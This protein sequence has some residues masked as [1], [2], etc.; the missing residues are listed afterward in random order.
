M[1]T[2]NQQLNEI[3]PLSVTSNIFFADLVLKNTL[4]KL[5]DLKKGFI[6][7]FEG[8]YKEIKLK[9]ISKQIMSSIFSV[10]QQIDKTNIKISNYIT[11]I[12]MYESFIN[13]L[14]KIQQTSTL[15]GM[16]KIMDSLSGFQEQREILFDKK[17]EAE[18]ELIKYYTKH[19]EI[20]A[21]DLLGLTPN[22]YEPNA[23]VF[24]DIIETVIFA[25]ENRVLGI[26]ITDS[27]LDDLHT[28]Y[29]KANRISFDENKSNLEKI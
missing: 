17:I 22:E 28:Q 18:N 27:I 20:I 15:D 9:P 19:R 24:K 25:Y 8:K 1:S 21:Y 5:K 14:T 16:T 13:D 10:M 11:K 26:E 29:K 7:E 23:S 4:E 3:V 2:D 12:R 6:V